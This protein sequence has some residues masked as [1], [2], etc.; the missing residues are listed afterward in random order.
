VLKCLLER[1]DVAELCVE[2]GILSHF[3]A[4]CVQR[5]GDERSS[6]GT[7]Q[8]AALLA[9]DIG[10]VF[11]H[12][13]SLDPA[14]PEAFAKA[15]AKPVFVLT[16]ACLSLET[17]PFRARSRGLYRRD[18]SEEKQNNNI[19]IY[20]YISKET[21]QTRDVVISRRTSSSPPRAAASRRWRR[22][23]SGSCS[24]RRSDRSRL[25]GGL[26]SAVGASIVVKRCL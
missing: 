18:L 12:H 17:F 2:Q 15:L 1:H 25:F 5:L 10:A 9:T 20:I 13:P 19:Y 11:G 7:Q 3:L 8:A 6:G 23:A 24:R 14:A 16:K 4:R 21:T 22:R 26:Q